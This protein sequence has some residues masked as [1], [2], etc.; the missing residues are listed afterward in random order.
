MGEGGCLLVLREETRERPESLPLPILSGSVSRG[1]AWE[2]RR[3]SPEPKRGS[4]VADPKQSLQQSFL[5][6]GQLQ[7]PGGEPTAGNTTRRAYK[8]H[9]DAR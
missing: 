2:S 8:H 4:Q 9:A 5:F 7:V 6:R 3:L 1:P